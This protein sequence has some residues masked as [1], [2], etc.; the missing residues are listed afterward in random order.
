MSSSV[1]ES[2]I[3]IRDKKEDIKRKIRGAYCK[4]GDIRNNLVLQLQD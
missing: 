4:P 1:K 3:S 2:F